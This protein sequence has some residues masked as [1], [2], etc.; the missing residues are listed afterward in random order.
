MKSWRDELYSGEEKRLN[1][2][3]NIIGSCKENKFFFFKVPLKIIM[4]GRDVGEVEELLE[5]E[6]IHPSK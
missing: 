2:L 3:E 6:S 4:N 5:I 1:S